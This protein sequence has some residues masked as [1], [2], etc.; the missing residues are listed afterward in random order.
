MANVYG[1]AG[2]GAMTQAVNSATR[3]ISSQIS[4]SHKEK[5]TRVLDPVRK[6]I[7]AALCM[8]VLIGLIS[9]TW[10][11]VAFSGALAL[12]LWFSS[13]KKPLKAPEKM[14]ETVRARVLGEYQKLREGG[15]VKDSPFQGDEISWALGA[16]A[17]ERTAEKLRFGLNKVF[18]VIHDI[19]IFDSRQRVSANIDHLVLSDQ[20]STMIDTKVWRNPL[21]FTTTS[22][23]CWLSKEQNPRTWPAVSTCLYEAFQLPVMPRAI[24]FAVAGQA[25]RNLEEQGDFPMQVTKFFERY[26]DAALKPCPVP[27]LFVPQSQVAEAV[28]WVERSL[29]S[30]GVP[31][32]VASYELARNL[33]F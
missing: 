29:P 19:E 10:V 4:T 5:Q 20:G 9:K 28:K 27:V 12:M 22:G 16:L 6:F 13:P 23:D 2:H 21:A 7:F 26:G 25:G 32:T 3:R 30:S 14:D 31:L 15:E 1:S 18:D 11:F 33:R 17:E 8:F 24:I